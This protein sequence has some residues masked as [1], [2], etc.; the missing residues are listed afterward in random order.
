MLCSNISHITNPQKPLH[1]A[2]DHISNIYTL[3]YS[4]NMG[5]I[6][7]L[8]HTL[9]RAHTL[10]QRNGDY[11]S[12]RGTLLQTLA[13]TLTSWTENKGREIYPCVRSCW[14]NNI[15]IAELLE[16]LSIKSLLCRMRSTKN[17]LQEIQEWWGRDREKE[18]KTNMRVQERVSRVYVWGKSSQS[19]LL[20]FIALTFTI[21]AFKST[22]LLRVRVCTCVFNVSEVWLHSEL[23][24]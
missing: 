14:Q 7:I 18:S 21:T 20:T 17:L 13:L 2:G 19:T 8:H 10:E 23:F 12:H 15:L 11:N 3:K 1:W 5:G 4:Q 22:G 9:L 6:H 24:P 16:K